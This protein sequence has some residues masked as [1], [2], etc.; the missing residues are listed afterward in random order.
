[1]LFEGQGD[2]EAEA[3]IASRAFVSRSHDA[4]A[5]TGDDHHVRAYERGAEFSRHRVQRMFDRRARRTE[6]SHLAPPPELFEH[7]EGLLEFS[8]GLQGDL[9]VPAIM[10]VLGHAQH[11]QDH[12]AV[13]REV[14]AVG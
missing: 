10:V 9:G 11:G 7:A 8:Q 6:H 3:V 13:N 2:V 1:M 14:R 5:S 12:V 4:A